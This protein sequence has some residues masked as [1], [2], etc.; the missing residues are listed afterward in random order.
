[1]SYLTHLKRAK[2]HHS[3]RWIVKYDV[4]NLIKEVKLIF[5]P[6]EYR[7]FP[8]AKKLNTQDSVIKT[9]RFLDCIYSPGTF[10]NNNDTNQNGLSN[11][12]ICI[13]IPN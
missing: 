2:H 11:N 8:N 10:F 6:K 5:N 13:W 4:N 1:M 3:C 12:T 9:T 7:K